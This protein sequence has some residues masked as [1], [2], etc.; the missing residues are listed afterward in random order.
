METPS[1]VKRCDQSD[2]LAKP[3]DYYYMGPNDWCPQRAVI[4]NCLHCGIPHL[5][6]FKP[7]NS[8]SE[9]L[10]YLEPVACQY[11]PFHKFKIEHGQVTKLD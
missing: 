5:I 9:P 1:E 3:G 10:T 4:M 2:E 11:S 6:T 7:Q 8:E